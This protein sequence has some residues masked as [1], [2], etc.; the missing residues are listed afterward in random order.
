MQIVHVEIQIKPESMDAFLEATIENARNSLQEPGILRFDFLQHSEDPTRFLL[1][2]VYKTAEDIDLHKQTAH[3]LK[4][5]DSAT[6]M[7]AQPRVGTKYRNIYPG[8]D[9][10]G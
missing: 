2:E 8:E 4:W 5:R 6:E 9:G 7:M 10:W 3:Y 1:Y